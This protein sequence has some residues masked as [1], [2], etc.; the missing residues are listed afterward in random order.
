MWELSP[1]VIATLPQEAQDHIAQLATENENKAWALKEMRDKNKELSTG[2]SV[3]DDATKAE[4]DELRT[5]RT[6]VETE[7]TTQEEADALKRWEHETVIASKDAKITELEWLVTDLG[8]QTTSYA[9]MFGSM[10]S[11]QLELIPE[12]EIEAVQVVLDNTPIWQKL[13]VVGKFVELHWGVNKKGVSPTAPWKRTTVTD[14]SEYKRAIA[15]WNVQLAMKLAPTRK[16][17]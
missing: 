11:S 6:S 17:R 8:G 12:A 9:E 14:D 3:M 7:K 15:E 13:T 16:L 5:F 1:E 2:V 4:L 10:V